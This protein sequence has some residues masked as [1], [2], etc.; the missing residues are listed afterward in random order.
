[1][2]L[3]FGAV[4]VQPSEFVKITFVVYL[5]HHLTRYRQKI[6]AWDEPISSRI[7]LIPPFT[8]AFCRHF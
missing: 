7:T 1:M 2:R 6:G 5:T 8:P 4:Q 3:S